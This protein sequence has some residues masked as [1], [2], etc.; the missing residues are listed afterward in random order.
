MYLQGATRSW[1]PTLPQHLLEAS[2]AT[3]GRK[4]AVVR[5]L[6]FDFALGTCIP[7][8]NGKSLGRGKRSSELSRFSGARL[9][10]SNETAEGVAVDIG[11]HNTL[12]EIKR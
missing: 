3:Q 1:Y 6:L 7:A 9:R 10:F 2:A 4:D 11:L 12:S 8:S 5:T